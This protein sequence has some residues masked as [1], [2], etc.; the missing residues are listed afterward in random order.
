VA[1][2]GVFTCPKTSAAV[3]AQGDKLTWV[4]ADGEFDDKAAALVEGNLIGSSVS[5]FEAGVN[6]QLTIKVR[7]C[8]LPGTLVPSQG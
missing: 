4:V 8:G 1:L 7:F 2:E 5:A 3:I 6:E